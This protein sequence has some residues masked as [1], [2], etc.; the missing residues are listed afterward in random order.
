M[1]QHILGRSVLAVALATLAAVPSAGQ[2]GWQAGLVPTT[3]PVTALRQ[4]GTDVFVQAGSWYR[5]TACGDEVCLVRGRPPNQTTAR[6]GIPDGT[7]ASARGTGIVEAWYADPTTRYDHGI[8]GD[9]VEGGTLIVVDAAGRQ[10]QV[11]LGPAQ[12]F[13]D[14]TPRIADID[15]DGR[16]DVVVIRSGLT[17]GAAIAVYGLANGALVE[18][19]S[20]PPIGSSH[21]W[22]NVAGIAD[23]NED[24]WLDIA[25]VKTPHIGGTLEIWSMPGGAALMR[26]AAASGFS[27]HAIGT[28]E[29]GMSAVADIDGD[30]VADLALPDNQRTT[31]RLVTLRGAAINDLA[32][33]PL[34]VAFAT[35]IGALTLDGGP[36]FL[37]GLA[38][39]TLAVIRQR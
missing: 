8:L 38:N 19:G 37:A 15:G 34:G 23:F 28:T 6:G 3:Q 4:V 24:G 20:S 11:T 1:R 31:L 12:V 14:L 5:A 7:V 25:L 9:Q 17:N 21:R 26:L 16:N 29:L 39:G 22:L 32:A 27:N 18:L 10:Y 30:G 13:E 35:A 2:V 36:V 33:V